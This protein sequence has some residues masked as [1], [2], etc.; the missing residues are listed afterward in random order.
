MKKVFFVGVIVLTM[1]TMITDNKAQA[2]EIQGNDLEIILDVSGSMAGLVE[3]RA[4]IDVAKEAIATVVNQIPDSS[5]VGFRAY[6]HQHHKSQKNCT[7]TE[8]IFPISKINKQQIISKVNSLQPNGW[9][10]IEYSLRQA[11]KDFS[12]KSEFGKMIILVS[13]GE[14]SCGGDPCAAV[15]D[16]KSAGFNVVVNTVGFD[17]SAVAEKQLKCIAAATGGEYKSAKNA[18][19][20]IDS[21]TFFSQRAF[22]GFANAGGAAAG[23]GF[24]NAPLVEAGAYG[25]DIRTGET[26]FYKVNVKK[27]QE[28]VAA[29]SIKRE[30]AMSEK[31]A[32][33]MC[34]LPVVKIHDKYQ[35]VVSELVASGCSTGAFM[36]IT[37]G[38][39]SGS[40]APASYKSTFVAEK[41]G[42]YYISIGNDW[43]SD[44][45]SYSWCLEWEAEKSKKDKAQYDIIIA[46][47]GEGAP[48]E[49]VPTTKAST[50]ETKSD[51]QDGSMTGEEASTKI[52]DANVVHSSKGVVTKGS[53]F[54]VMGI[55]GA[56]SMIILIAIVFLVIKTLK[57]KKIA[58]STE[59]PLQQV[60]TQG[61]QPV[62]E[63]AD[64]ASQS[65]G[66]SESQNKCSKCGGVNEPGA[67]FC[68]GCGGQLS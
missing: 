57:K 45:G 31:N 63:S 54:M 39:K 47:E 49:Q 2:V 25:G 18:Q 37:P 27:G 30:Q 35:T 13:D 23:T 29:L 60:A 24:T 11:K 6:G 19:G 64:S 26:K 53:N 15:K 17:V 12:N 51:T 32:G 56:L 68:S 33:S 5:Y 44:C 40:T 42:E 22:E 9:T 8:L 36:D 34:M 52:N 58:Q 16:M 3:G 67:R 65:E 41:A 28:I 66:Q 38:L 14:E 46:V 10:P 50:D 61:A 21:M 4:K 43:R 20:L 7:D 48:G 59:T 55:V 1:I 62:N